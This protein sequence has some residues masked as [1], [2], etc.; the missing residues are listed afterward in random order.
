MH[1]PTS[2]PAD[3]GLPCSTQTP[4]VILAMSHNVLIVLLDRACL[5]ATITDLGLNK[6][7]RGLQNL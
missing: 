3:H 5:T 1:H 7:P 2:N 4:H 6:S